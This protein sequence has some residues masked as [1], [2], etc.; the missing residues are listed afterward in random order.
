MKKVEREYRDGKMYIKGKECCLI[1]G[2]STQSPSPRVCYEGKEHMFDI[3]KNDLRVGQK[4][5]YDVE[6]GLQ[7]TAT[8][9]RIFPDGGIQ[10]FVNRKV[11]IFFRPNE[12]SEMKPV[13]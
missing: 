1:C 2:A 12:L 4:I 6:G 11:D 9:T 13:S 3:P 7:E 10:A 8:I 5:V